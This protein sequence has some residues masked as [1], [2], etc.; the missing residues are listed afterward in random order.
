[1][2]FS[3]IKMLFGLINVEQAKSLARDAIKWLGVLFLAKGVGDA[4]LW[5]AAAGFGVAAVGTIW[6]Q[7]ETTQKNIVAKAAAIVP[8]EPSAQVAAG[9]HPVDIV[10]PGDK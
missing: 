3:P 6:S 4:A 8:I 5:E 2:N 1:M 10:Q 7:F 9:V